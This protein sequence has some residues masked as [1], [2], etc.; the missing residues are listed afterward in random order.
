M[1]KYDYSRAALIIGL[2]L[3]YIVEKNLI[4]SYDLYGLSFLLR[5]IT[6]S[7]L[8]ILVMAFLW[9]VIKPRISFL[10]KKTV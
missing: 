4:I 10:S 2:V 3:G 6:F 5:P 1:K 8:I 9:P 7:M